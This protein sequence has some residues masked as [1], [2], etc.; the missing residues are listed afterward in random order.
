VQQFEKR[1]PVFNIPSVIVALIA[2]MAFVHFILTSILTPAENDEVLWLFA[3]NP[4]RYTLGLFPPK[5]LPGYWAANVWTFVTYAFLHGSWAHFIVNA[6]WFL[7]F[8][9]AL[10]RRFGTIRFLIFFV[11]TA[12]AGALTHLLSYGTQD[13]PM[14]GASATISGAMAGAMRFAFQRGGPLSFHR[15][16]SEADYLVPAIPLSRLLREPA[17]IVFIIVWFGINLLFGITSWSLGGIG[18]GDVVA[19]QAH[20]GGFLAGLLLFSWIDPAGS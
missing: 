18:A 19:W 6:I 12:A 16:G 2:I 5:V 8:G 4:A 13:A 14:I 20:I 17:A 9:S 1:E 15:T 10:A 7:P 3:F 11:M